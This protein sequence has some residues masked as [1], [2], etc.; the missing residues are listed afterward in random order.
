MNE[1]S[2]ESCGYSQDVMRFGILVYPLINLEDEAQKEISYAMENLEM[3]LAA[4]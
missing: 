2:Q 4:L 3:A 1:C